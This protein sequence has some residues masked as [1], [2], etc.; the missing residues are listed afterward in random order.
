MAERRL[1]TYSLIVSELSGH[2]Y[3]YIPTHTHAAYA[4][5]RA[6]TGR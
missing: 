2:H 5:S 6:R 4:R 3:T 1:N